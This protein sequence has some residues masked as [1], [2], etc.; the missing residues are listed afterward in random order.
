M[1]TAEERRKILEMVAEG[2]L[3]VSQGAQLLQGDVDVAES[4]PQ[5][6]E[7]AQEP[8][9]VEEQE[10]VVKASKQ[11]VSGETQWESE[12][13]LNWLHIR[14]DDN[15]SGRSKVQVNIPLGLLKFGAKLGRGVMPELSQDDWHLLRSSLQSGEGVLVDI[16]NEHQGE[17]VQVYLG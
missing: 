10:P 14:I 4:A 1:A 11:E 6:E 17:R 13:N 12:T 3:S 16:D 2:R 8:Q 5:S 7:A 9:T 15:K